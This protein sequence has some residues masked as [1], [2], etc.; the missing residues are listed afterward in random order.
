MDHDG[1]VTRLALA[2]GKDVESAAGRRYKGARCRRQDC[3]RDHR[4]ELEAS[5]SLTLVEL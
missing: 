2:A 3:I 5:I 4:K 1:H